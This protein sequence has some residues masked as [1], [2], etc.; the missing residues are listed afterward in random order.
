MI[1]LNHGSRADKLILSFAYSGGYFE[2]EAKVTKVPG[3]V[4]GIFT[5]H[6]DPWDAPLGWHD[7]QDIEILSSTV[8]TPSRYNEAGLQL[9]NFDPL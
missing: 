7:E 8:L 9:T 5:M 2:V 4:F 6:G 1:A 3:T